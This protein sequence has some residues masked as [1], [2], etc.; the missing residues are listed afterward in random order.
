VVDTPRIGLEGVDE[1]TRRPQQRSALT[2]GSSQL[3]SIATVPARDQIVNPVSAPS[4]EPGDLSDAAPLGQ[5]QPAHFS[6][7]ASDPAGARPIRV[8][9]N[10]RQ[11]IKTRDVKPVY[12]PLAA[13]AK[14]SGIVILE[15]TIGGDGR[16]VDARVIRSIPLLDQAALDAVRQWEFVPTLLN[17]VPAPIIMSVTVNFTLN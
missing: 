3:G 5:D 7:A 15:V 17:G 1:M 12:P 6:D 14:V 16:V 13:S 10:I 2:S 8:G 9:G 11:P 4:Q